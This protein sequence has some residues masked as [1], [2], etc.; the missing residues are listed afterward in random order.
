[1]TASASVASQPSPSASAAPEELAE[2]DGPAGL[3]WGQSPAEAKKVLS[4]KYTFLREDAADEGQVLEQTWNGEFAGFDPE[5]IFVDFFDKKRFLAFGV[6]FPAK[7]VR[8]AARRW[9]DLVEAT[10]KAHGPPWRFTPAPELPT[11][12]KL[13]ENYPDLPNKAKLKEL[14]AQID[15]LQGVAGSS[16]YDALDRKIARGDWEPM[17]LWK[18]KG[19]NTIA[20]KVDIGKPDKRGNRA[21]KPMWVAMS[22]EKVEWKKSTRASDL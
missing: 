12:Q 19:E 4:A 15:A 9:L 17:A 2:Y 14:A 3:R 1:V 16:G 8:P 11:A 5:S 10:T 18:F 7:D 21:L 6:T 13:A 22:G 20:V